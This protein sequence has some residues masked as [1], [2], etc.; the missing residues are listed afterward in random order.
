MNSPFYSIILAMIRQGTPNSTIAE[1]CITRGYMDVTQ[2]T[3]ISYLQYFRKTRAQLCRPLALDDASDESN[4]DTLFDANA[5]ALDEETELLR[6]IA[7]Q[8]AR[9]GITY[10]NERNLGTLLSSGHKDVETLN[11]LL[12]ALAKLRGKIGRSIDMNFHGYPEGVRDDLKGIS[13]DEKQRDMLSTLVGGLVGRV[14]NA[15]S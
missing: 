3:A 8:K 13:H 9:L 14:G 5:I 12:E 10:K 15:N 1:H 7:L 11:N 4:I 2:K 6:L